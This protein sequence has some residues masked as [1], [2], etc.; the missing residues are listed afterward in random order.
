MSGFKSWFRSHKEA[1]QSGGFFYGCGTVALHPCKP[2]TK[3]GEFSIVHADSVL[4]AG[5]GEKPGIRA[6][7]ICFVV[8]NCPAVGDRSMTQRK[9]RIRGAPPDDDLPGGTLYLRTPPGGTKVFSA[10]WGAFRWGIF[11]GEHAY[12]AFF[13]VCRLY[14]RKSG[15]DV[16]VDRPSF[17]SLQDLTNRENS[18][19]LYYKMRVS[20]GKL[21]RT[22][23]CP[24][25]KWRR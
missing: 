10:G 18:A 7:C 16:Y 9:P 21:C 12:F 19:K 24:S 23:C 25:E 1:T 22:N 5:H 15:Q 6:Q 11:C 8:Q 4:S 20:E 2:R 3:A 13:P 17:L 14:R